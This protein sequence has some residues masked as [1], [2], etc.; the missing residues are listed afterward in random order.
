MKKSLLAAAVLFCSGFIFTSCLSNSFS[1]TESGSPVVLMQVVTNTHVPYYSEETRDDEYGDED[2]ILSNA[3]NGF[4]GKNNPEIQT[5][6]DRAL[7]IEEAFRRLMAENAGIEVLDK[8]ILFES[9]TYK[10]IG[11]GSVMSYLD[12]KY[13]LPDYKFMDDIGAKKARLICRETGA[14]S[15]VFL[16]F[17]FKKV[18]ADGSNL[19]GQVAARAEMEITVYNDQGK[20]VIHDTSVTQSLET[21]E[22]YL[23]KYDKDAVVEMFPALIEE[24]INKFIVKYL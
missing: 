12:V 22:L 16:N 18:I 8:Q 7:Y 20:R 10:N 23:T 21:T 13:R 17:T 3:I 9:P 5:V 19:K 11:E 4:L 2:G 24:L 1:M 6:P 14:K 15:L